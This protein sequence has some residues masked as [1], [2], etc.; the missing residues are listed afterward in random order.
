MPVFPG[1]PQGDGGVQT[2]AFGQESLKTWSVPLLQ[3]PGLPLFLMEQAIQMRQASM[4]VCVGE[5]AKL[6]RGILRHTLR[7]ASTGDA[8]G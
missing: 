2:N 6:C 3:V 5:A 7:Y 8:R 4:P 1:F